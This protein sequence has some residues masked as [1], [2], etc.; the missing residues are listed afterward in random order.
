MSIALCVS[1]HLRYGHSYRRH[2]SQVAFQQVAGCILVSYLMTIAN[3]ASE[4][5][6][7]NSGMVWLAWLTC[8]PELPLDHEPFQW[9]QVGGYLVQ[10]RCLTLRGPPRR[11]CLAQ[12]EAS[13]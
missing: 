7:A 9:T 8:A 4:R 12:G 2:R 5:L 1:Y 11:A 3:E 13:A 6:C 10:E